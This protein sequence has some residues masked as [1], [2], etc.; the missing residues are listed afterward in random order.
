MG[1]KRHNK[2]KTMD[3]RPVVSAEVSLARPL[4]ASQ[5][6]LDFSSQIVMMADSI[7]E[8]NESENDHPQEGDEEDSDWQKG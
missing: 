2:M 4:M 5:T 1:V 8:A 7:E 6:E 3:N